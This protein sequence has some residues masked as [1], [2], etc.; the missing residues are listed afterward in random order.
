MASCGVGKGDG[1]DAELGADG[2]P[3][4]SGLGDGVSVEEVKNKQQ[5][6][7]VIRAKLAEE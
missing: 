4:E 2:G 6:R 1:A 7:G 5:Q 3:V